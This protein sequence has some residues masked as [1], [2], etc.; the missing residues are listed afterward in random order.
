MTRT[1]SPEAKRSLEEG[2]RRIWVFVAVAVVGAL[3]LGAA[4]AALAFRAYGNSKDDEVRRIETSALVTSDDYSQFL[5]GRALVLQALASSDSLVRGDTPGVQARLDRLKPAKD[6]RLTQGVT[7]FDTES[8]ARASKGANLTLGTEAQGELRRTLAAARAGS[9]TQI[10]GSIEESLYRMP[11]VV[12]VVPT[13]AADGR[14][15][16]GTLVGAVGTTWLNDR[17][18]MRSAV[19]GGDTQIYDRSGN[20]FLAP[21]LEGVRQVG[22]LPVVRRIRA[23]PTRSLDKQVV[24]GLTGVTNLLGQGDRVIGFATDH[25]RPDDASRGR[26]DRR[27]RQRVHLE[28]PRPRRPQR[29]LLGPPRGVPRSRRR[30]GPR[31]GPGHPGRS[32]G[33]RRRR[34]AAGRLGVDSWP[35]PGPGRDRRCP[36]PG[37]TGRSGS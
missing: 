6:L 19:R 7:W 8:V 18:L 37:A 4:A 22:D 10:S 25:P 1:G 24:G 26:R 31:R 21:G 34:R 23:Q 15:V 2:L 32:P 5:S 16:T 30:L 28:H 11:V 33:G 9:T 35:H 12:V 14:T 36:A 17:A 13:F 20:L 27:R 3:I 29:A